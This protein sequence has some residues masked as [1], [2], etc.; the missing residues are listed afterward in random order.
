LYNP[1]YIDCK[2][3][4]VRNDCQEISINRRFSVLRP[5]K[6][7]PSSILLHPS[8]QAIP[9]LNNVVETAQLFN[10]MLEYDVFLLTRSCAILDLAAVGADE[11]IIL[12]PANHILPT[13][14]AP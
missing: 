2:S 7:D 13:Y 12:R 11:A 9:H 1:K 5:I 3:R 8:I 6:S 14:V 4:L 10:D